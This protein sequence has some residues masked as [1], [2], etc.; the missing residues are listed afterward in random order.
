MLSTY[1]TVVAVVGTNEKRKTLKTQS[2]I[3]SSSLSHSGSR[4]ML[5]RIRAVIVGID[6]YPEPFSP[7]TSAVHDARKIA[8]FL[9]E[10]FGAEEANIILLKDSDATKDQIIESIS[11][12]TRGA[13][14][15]DPFIFFFSGYAGKALPEGS[16]DGE[17]SQVGIICPVDVSQKGGISDKSLL[18]TF[19]QVAKLCGNNI[20]STLG[21]R[22]S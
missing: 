1:H 4:I 14:R 15:D 20:V 12:L 6:N 21:I 2:Y 13:I 7:L 18:Q 16:E 17:S 22:R 9:K 19:D 8:N 11:S 5:P 10:K 3:V